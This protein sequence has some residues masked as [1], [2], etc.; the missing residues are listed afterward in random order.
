MLDGLNDLVDVFRANMPFSFIY[1]LP[2]LLIV[3]NNVNCAQEFQVYRMQ[4]YDMPYGNHYGSRANLLNMEART[5][6]SRSKLDTSS[7]LLVSRRCILIKLND[8]NLEI[9]R[10]LVSQYVGAIL[11][12]LPVKYDVEQ[13]DLIKSFELQMLHEDIKIPVYFIYETNEVLSYYDY[14]DNASNNNQQTQ[15]AFKALVDAVFTNGFQFVVNSQQSQPL[16]QSSN[17]HQAVNLQAKL[18]GLFSSSLSLN[19]SDSASSITNNKIPTII[20]TAHYDSLGMATS[21]SYGCDSN[22]SGVI[23]L[24]ELSRILSKLYSKSKTTPPLNIVFLLTTQGKFNYH[25]L[26]KWIEEQSET[27]EMVGKIDLDDVVVSICL[28]SLAKA[29][30]SS[31][32]SLFMHVSRPP[33]EGQASHEFQNYLEKAANKLNTQFELVHKKINLA[34]EILAWEHERFSLNKIPAFT[35]SHFQSHKDADRTSMTDTIDSIDMEIFKRNINIILRS[36]YQYMY[37]VENVDDHLLV[38]DLSVSEEFL[39]SWLSQVCNIPRSASLLNKNHPFITNIFHHF[40]HY[41]QESVKY[42]VR[43][44]IKEPEFVFYNEE[45]ATLVINS[46]KPAVF[47]FFLS[48]I[49][50]AYIGLIYLFVLN[51]NHLSFI[52]NRLFFL[53]QSFSNDINNSLNGFSSSSI[54]SKSS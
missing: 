46:V 22:G 1:F 40:N 27:N 51:F 54:K 18:N 12:V 20:I 52:L 6:S 35:L 39:R 34:S 8:F 10:Q 32:S 30:L 5:I 48:L 16:V 13:R 2:L 19:K 15:S 28:D 4:Q 31:A 17:E 11:I 24:L 7:G 42:P 33:K 9:Y 53:N 44:Q 41:L 43:L 47:D 14:I 26:K 45:Q 25:G 21:L 23:A 38:D 50:S 49:I 3:T 29:S 37:K 36:I